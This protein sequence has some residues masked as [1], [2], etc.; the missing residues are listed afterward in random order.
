MNFLVWR[1]WWP[2]KLQNL[3][4]AEKPWPLSPLSSALIA[5]CASALI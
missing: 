5:A 2:V 3:A 1:V 4:K